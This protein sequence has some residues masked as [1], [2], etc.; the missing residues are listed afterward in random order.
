MTNPAG[1]PKDKLIEMAAGYGEPGINLALFIAAG[2]LL[3]QKRW[4]GGDYATH[5]LWVA[6]VMGEQFTDEEKIVGIL[7]DVIEDSDW[8]IEDLE[9]LGFSARI[10]RAVDRLTKHENVPYLD[11]A[12]YCG[13]DPIARKIKKRDNRHNM[14]L[15]NS[16]IAATPKQRC[17]YHVSYAY[18]EAI[19]KDGV[20]VGQPM[21]KFLMMP[22]YKGLLT[23]ET[24][25]IIAAAIGETPPLDVIRR[26][27]QPPARQQK[28][29][30]AGDSP[31]PAI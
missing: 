18:L 6:D 30:P 16:L 8:E 11:G 9:A 27:G 29:K 22:K 1:I 4:D 24:Y 5:W 25:P 13:H 10:C 14:Q 17:L 23:D 31:A 2:A 26:F 28:R 20:P 7:H 21:W 12:V 19:D 3:K 15:T